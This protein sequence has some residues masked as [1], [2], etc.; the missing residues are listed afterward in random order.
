MILVKLFNYLR[1]FLII[2]VEGH[3]VERFMNI[4]MRRN[5][6]LWDIK[7]CGR[8]KKQ[9]NVSIPGFKKLIGISYKTRSSVKILKR[10]GIFFAFRNY[11]RRYAL[12]YGLLAFMFFSQVISWF[13]WDIKVEGNS[14]ISTDE[15]LNAVN[16]SGLSVGQ[17]IPA[18]D[19]ESIKLKTMIEIPELAFLGITVHGTKV[20][21]EIRERV[22][23]PYV[24]EK[25]KPCNIISSAD[26]IIVG[27]DV[28]S[29]EPKVKVGDV[30]Y[31]GQLLVSGVQDSKVL[32]MRLIH[33]SADVKARTWRNFETTVNRVVE[34]RV[35]TGKVKKKISAKI[36]GFNINFFINNNTSFENYDKINESKNLSIGKNISLP[37]TVN[38]DIYKEV[39]IV[40]KEITQSE[41]EN[42]AKNDL[43]EKIK[44]IG[45][46]EIVSASYRTIV[47]EDGREVLQATFECI[48][49]I[50]VKEEVPEAQ[51]A[52]FEAE[53]LKRQQ[54][55]EQNKN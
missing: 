34:E 46:A 17:F 10:R 9:M 22:P 29:G 40:K 42:A 45:E 53:I 11:R 5:I 6:Y 48:E 26:G 2:S 12:I 38:S 47:E 30:V 4:C 24:I 49:N 7:N 1:G 31:L 20:I 18:I 51:I 25:D 55:E 37:I 15:I 32:G 16:S 43:A 44:T 8:N 14:K 13:V 28:S 21:V 19:P 27:L 52:Q 54:E 3:F 23:T 35:P 33:S 39:E 41:A 50:S 36:F